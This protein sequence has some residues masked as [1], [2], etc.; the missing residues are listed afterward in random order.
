MLSGVRRAVRAASLALLALLVVTPLAQIV[1][2]G[3][4]NVPMAGAEELARYFLV[5][6]TF[7]GAAYVTHAGGQIRMEELQA[8][9]PP[10]PR[11]YLQLG[12]ELVGVA[13]FATLFVAGAITIGK[14]LS[15]KTATLEMPFWLFMGPLAVGSLLLLVETLAM[16]VHTLRRR[17]PEDKHTVLT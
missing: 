4:F 8:L 15:N 14:N 1:M 12:I 2:R 11:W 7:L 9:L 6:L 13:M 5:C 17:R 3:V 10:R 16:F